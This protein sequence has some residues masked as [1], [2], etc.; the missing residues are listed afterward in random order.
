MDGSSAIEAA[1]SAHV[2]SGQR[3]S[4]WLW[5]MLRLVGAALMVALAVRV[6]LAQPFSIPSR[7]MEPLL[8]PGDFV[9]VDKR[10]YGWSLASLPLAAPLTR[11][12][13]TPGGRLWGGAPARG[14]VLAFVGPDGRDYVK[15]LVAVGGDRVALKAGTVWLNGRALPQAP[16]GG[17]Y[18]RERLPGGASYRVACA[19]PGAL[20]DFAEIR[21]PEGQL[22][23]LGDNRGASTD[24]RVLP[25]YGGIGLV[26]E[27]QLIGRAARVF[28]SP[29]EGLQWTAIE[30][31]G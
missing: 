11:P 9:L 28:F 21:V 5:P 27:G 8:E 16:T 14:E 2:A 3:L 17:G 12:A 13:G 26:P 4:E 6:L 23:L 24:S 1:R 29:G 19:A 22:F 10:A 20:A 25:A 18:C 7:S 15:R 31:A 30:P